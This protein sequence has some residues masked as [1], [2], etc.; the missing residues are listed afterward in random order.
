[1]LLDLILVAIKDY[2]VNKNCFI[3]KYL[4]MNFFWHFNNK[5]GTFFN[6]SKII[7]NLSIYSPDTNSL[8]CTIRGILEAVV[9][10]KPYKSLESLK[11]HL[12]KIWKQIDQSTVRASIDQ[13]N[14]SG[15]AATQT[16]E[17]S[18]TISSN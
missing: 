18:K 16:K 14:V 7:Y 3:I 13:W 1:M 8:E 9:C 2:N 4:S 11:R 17:F 15:L 10:F 12:M 6:K 5:L